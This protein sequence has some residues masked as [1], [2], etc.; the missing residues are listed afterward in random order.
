[1]SEQAAQLCSSRTQGRG[2]A[3][4]STVGAVGVQAVRSQRQVSGDH[5]PAQEPR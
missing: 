3:G 2:W 1:M 4:G 5:G